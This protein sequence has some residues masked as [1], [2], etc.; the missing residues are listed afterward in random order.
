MKYQVYWREGFEAAV[1]QRGTTCPYLP[2][3]RE[4]D[5]WELGWAEGAEARPLRSV[6]PLG[7][8][9]GS[10]LRGLLKRLLG[11]KDTTPAR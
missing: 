2:E 3:S 9:G 11:R 8:E 5:A 4:A 6:G 7:G 10:H 1:G